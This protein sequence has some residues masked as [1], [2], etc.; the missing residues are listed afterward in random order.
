MMLGQHLH[1][2][3]EPQ[4]G[5]N[6]FYKKIRHIRKREQPIREKKNEDKVG[7]QRASLL[8]RV[9]TESFGNSTSLKFQKEGSLY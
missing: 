7:F 4:R 5:R 2:R 8:M 9:W 1:Q 6:F 3:R